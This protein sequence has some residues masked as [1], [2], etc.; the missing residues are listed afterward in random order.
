MKTHQLLTLHVCKEQQITFKTLEIAEEHCIVCNDEES[1]PDETHI[2]SRCIVA[3]Q[4]NNTLWNK[5]CKEIPE[6]QQEQTW[7]TT[8]NNSKSSLLTWTNELGDTGHIPTRVTKM[9]NKETQKKLAEMIVESRLN[10][11]N[12]YWKHYRTL[13]N[14]DENA[15]STKNSQHP[16]TLG[17]PPPDANSNL[18][19]AATQENSGGLGGG[20]EGNLGEEQRRKKQTTLTNYFRKVQL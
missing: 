1:I 11:W 19:L 16:N 12:Q 14:T 13:T 4:E 17:D 5:V 15:S 2:F 20:K 18:E 10:L 8:E 7:F 3:A 9:L 6:L